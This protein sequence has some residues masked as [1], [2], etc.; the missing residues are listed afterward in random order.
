MLFLITPTALCSGRRNKG[1]PILIGW[2]PAQNVPGKMPG[3]AGK[4][5]GTAG[6]M[7]GTAGKTPALPGNLPPPL[8]LKFQV[9]EEEAQGHF[10]T[11]I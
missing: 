3:T 10:K 4:M 6:K 1:H 5:P 9:S 11:P 8:Q 7:P 2:A